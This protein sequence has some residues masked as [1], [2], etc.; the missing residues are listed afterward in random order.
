MGGMNLRLFIGFLCLII[1]FQTFGQDQLKKNVDRDKGLLEKQANES[2]AQ[3]LQDNQKK[4]AKTSKKKVDQDHK[5]VWVEGIL[6]TT[7]GGH[8]YDFNNRKL[9]SLPVLN[10]KLI[11]GG[12]KRVTR[13]SFTFS[14]GEWLWYLIQ[15]GSAWHVEGF[16]GKRFKSGGKFS[17]KSPKISISLK[18]NLK[19]PLGFY[20]LS[21]DPVIF[22][23]LT[24]RSKAVIY[25]GE[26]GSAL[27]LPKDNK[28]VKVHANNISDHMIFEFKNKPRYGK[29]SADA[30]SLNWISDASQIKAL[31]Q[32][33]NNWYGTPLVRAGKK[34]YHTKNDIAETKVAFETSLSGEVCFM[35]SVDGNLLLGNSKI[36]ERRHYRS[37]ILLDRIK[38]P[39][40]FKWCLTQ[41]F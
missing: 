41:S 2:K 26:S 24:S 19:T 34:F 1:G 12:N 15:I 33:L 13:D 3:L 20:V 9:S 40:D 27:N 17:I 29:V 21:N 4:Q 37:F 31:S 7:A 14:K 39:D 23:V 11:S 18:E 35:Q 22:V 8:V 6:R 32:S 25:K 28:L 16:Q 10:P 36:I 5:D 38:V 30:R